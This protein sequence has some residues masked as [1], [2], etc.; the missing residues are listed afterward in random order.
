MTA[1]LPFDETKLDKLAQ[2]SVQ[3]GLALEQGQDL[4]ITAPAEALP[5]VRRI[6]VH[7]YQAGAGVVTPLLS[8]PEI[9][10][11]RYAHG[12]ASSFDTAA[13]W[14]YNG[15]AEA[16]DNNTARLAIVGDDPM[17]LSGQDPSSVSRVNKAMSKAHLPALE[18]ITQFNVNWNIVSWPGAVWAKRVFPEL[19]TEAAQAQLADAIFSTSR[20]VGPDPIS[21]WRAHNDMLRNRTNWLND[22][23]FA[24]LNFT[25]PGTDLRVG[26]A[27]QHAWM[28]GASTAKN[29][30]TCNPNIPTEEVFTT[31]HATKVEGYV[32]STKPLSHQGNLIE[33]IEVRFEKG[34]IV[35]AKASKGEDV[36]ISL[37]DSDAGAR[38]LGEVALVPHSS[39][40]S[41]S[42]LLFYN[43]L[44]DENAACHIALGQCY[45]KCFTDGDTASKEDITA[46]GGN[47]SMIHV[48]W[49]IGSQDINIDGISQD[50]SK[51]AVLR[52]GE[53]AF[54]IAGSEGPDNHPA[55]H[56]PSQNPAD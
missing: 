22:H 42:G 15:M 17:L 37:L 52:D 30:I 39:P 26:L 11:A 9:T 20:V 2:L 1:T 44:F 3:T 48:D 19:S 41:Q 55:K 31:P 45:S 50:G 24:A 10:L 54:S 51:M 29:G 4:L 43:T 33:N 40:I 46:R 6:A 13:N 16:F 53:W 8:D 18:R 47:S 35:D 32:R 14:L 5:L 56:H 27:E 25:G 49:M 21:E 7:A 34:N 28:G 36:L 12:S 38:R 23:R